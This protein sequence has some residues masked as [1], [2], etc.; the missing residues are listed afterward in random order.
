M[1]KSTY[2][3]LVIPCYNESQAIPEFLNEL[4]GFYQQ[5]RSFMQKHS[6]SDSQEKNMHVIFVNNNSTDG[7]EQSLRQYC[8]SH[9][10]C[11][12]IHCKQQ[13]YGAALKAGFLAEEAS[14]YGFTDLDGTYPLQD[15][16]SIFENI[17]DKTNAV[18]MYMTNRFSKKSEMPFMRSVGN[19]IY[20]LMCRIFFLSQLKDVCSGMR[21]FSDGKK[22]EIIKRS[23][24]GLDFSIALTATALRQKWNIKTFEINYK[25][26]VGPSKLSILKDGY[27]FLYTLLK[28]RFFE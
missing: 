9:D 7:S 4:T 20:A 21:V 6:G 22:S 10:Y 2:F 15:F 17:E 3:L 1:I 25:E 18:D 8:Q 24:N 14:Y 12:L 23:E 28:V 16:I 27:Q 19:R 26:R 5:Y 13:G 11:S